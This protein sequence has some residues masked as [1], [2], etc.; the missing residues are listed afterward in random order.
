MLVL[1]KSCTKAFKYAFLLLLIISCSDNTKKN[2]DST[3]SVSQKTK[4]T[5]DTIKVVDTVYKPI[6]VNYDAEYYI[7]ERLPEWFVDTKIFDYESL[8]I[9][10]TYRFDYRIHPFYLEADLNGDE[11]IDI[12][13]PVEH[14]K[15][16]KK[17]FAIIHGKTLDIH[18]VGA[19]NTFKNGQSDNLDYYDIWNINRSKINL[20][21]LEENT[22]TGPEGELIIETPSLRVEKSEVG[23]GLIYWNGK[24]YAYFHQTC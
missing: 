23:G 3:K 13:F 4:V 17:G 1:F 18:V 14:I 21:G 19:G 5:H 2:K 8:T 10:G 6:P 24:E 12:I 15:S 16:K 22:G 7:M 9:Q 11:N 20:P